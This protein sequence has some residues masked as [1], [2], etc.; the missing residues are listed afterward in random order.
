ML[1]VYCETPPALSKAMGRVV[2]ALKRESSHRRVEFVNAEEDADLVVLHVI[3]YPETVE[4]VNRIKT[5][6][7]QYVIIQY[8]MRSTQQP[9]TRFWKD[10]WTGAKLVWSYYDLKELI[11][12]DLHR[13]FD[14]ECISDSGRHEMNDDQCDSC[15]MMQNEIDRQRETLSENFHFHFYCSP[16]GAD[17]IFHRTQWMSV[18]MYTMLTSGFVAESE[19]VRE[20]CD[21]VA[22]VNGRVF[23]LG[24]RDAAPTAFSCGTGLSDFDLADIYSRCCWVAGLR[25]AEGFEMP[26]AEGLV[27]GARPI[28]FDAPHYRRWY[29]GFAE[30]IPEGTPD[31][32][33]E[34]L[35]RIFENGWEPVDEITRQLAVSRFSWSNIVPEFWEGVLR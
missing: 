11:A 35:V 7:Q 30:F 23:H 29:D 22:R 8:C 26:A 13:S 34:S 10:I 16:L 2:A 6:A 21:A 3:G 33:T 32:V 17:P 19:S 20:V 5:R 4:A 12:Q 18:K 24:P 14:R 31:E 27:C 1:K 28:V 9:D 15:M 25:R